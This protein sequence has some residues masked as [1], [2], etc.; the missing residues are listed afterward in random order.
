ML[1][2]SLLIVNLFF[3]A[4][5][6]NQNQTRPV[7]VADDILM[8]QMFSDCVTSKAAVLTFSHVNGYVEF[9]CAFQPNVDKTKVTFL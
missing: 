4:K 8:Q 9:N 2:V 1:F 5:I 6:Y 7:P 3:L